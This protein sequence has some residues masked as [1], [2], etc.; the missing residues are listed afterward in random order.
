MQSIH[1]H[2]PSDV[3]LCFLTSTATDLYDNIKHLIDRGIDGLIIAQYISSPDA[4]NNYLK[5]HHVPYVV[6]DQNDHQGYTDF[7]RTN[8][9]QGGQLAAQHLIELGHN[10]MMIVAPYDMMANM[11]TRVAGFVDTLRANQLPEPQIVHTE[12]SKRGGLTIV[13]DDIDY[14]AYV[15]PPLT[16]VAQPITDIGKTSL[17]LLLQRL[18]H[19]DKSI[20]MIE[21]PTTLKIRATTGY[22]LSN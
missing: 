9:Y 15:S 8:E 16:T 1:D 10:N 18:Q 7:V 22:H 13:D 3:D 17:T 2:K 11:S 20:D 6:L 4:L 12:L 14:A 21:L 19:L 5:K